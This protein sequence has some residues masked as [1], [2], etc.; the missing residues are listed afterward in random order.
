MTDLTTV[1]MQYC[2]TPY[3]WG[4]QNFTKFDC[5]GFVLTCMSDVGILLPD[6][7]ASGIFDWCLK[8]KGF[9]ECD[10]TSDC[11]LFYGKTRITHISIGINENLIIECGGGDSTF[12][13]FDLD[14]AVRHDARVRIKSN[15]LR[16][17]LLHCIK[18]FY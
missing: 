16:K 4:G 2:G 1:A 10:P 13:E 9:F 8:Q 15:K 3:I 12:K 6:M 5:S 7:T 11:L 18:I 14:K 17:D